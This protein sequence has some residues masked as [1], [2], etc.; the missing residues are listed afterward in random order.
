MI[1]GVD[2]NCVI[3]GRVGG[4]EGYAL[5]LV[6]AL[7]CHAGWVE[8]VV[9]FTREENHGLFGGLCG[10]KCTARLVERPAIDGRR[11]ENWAVVL[12]EEP[13]GGRR[14]LGEYQR[15]KVEAMHASGVEVVHFPGNTINPLDLDLPAV[16]N[17]HDLLYRHYPQYCTKEDLENRESYWTASAR[18]AD[19]M[20]AV[21]RFV[22][23]DLERELGVERARVFVA[24]PPVDEFYYGLAT[25]EEKRETRRRWGLG[26]VVFVYPAAAWP[27]KNHERLIRAF[28]RAGIADSQL[29]LT[30][31]G[32]EESGLG[33]LVESLGARESVK[34]LGRVGQGELRCLYQLA[35]ALVLPSEYEASS[36]PIM[37]AMAS[38]CVVASSNVTSLPELVGDAG[39]IFD[40][41][42]VDA[43]AEAMKRLAGDGELRR[44]LAARG[45]E[46]VGEFT[47]E[48][49]VGGLKRAYDCALRHFSMKEAA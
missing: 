19:A 11:I 26:G 24:H 33:G 13:A 6:R 35:T 40:P 9:L 48:S 20:L 46:R 23:E 47:M 39:R 15:R 7:S 12:R 2:T 49:Y 28:L 41:R 45:R 25:E 36:F 4:I 10:G 22:A 21:T 14:L 44:E 17:L 8:G 31:G 18:R 43:I 29:V 5:S 37:E 38:G 1:V 3:P 16:L 34:L 42:D 30:G 27:H 32:Q